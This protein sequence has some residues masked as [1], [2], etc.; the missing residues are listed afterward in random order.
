[1]APMHAVDVN[2]LMYARFDAQA[3]HES[4]Y[5]LLTDLRVDPAGLALFPAVINGF[6]RL[7]TDFRVITEPLSAQIAM[8]YIDELLASP[9]VRVVNPGAG[10]WEIF[11]RL[12]A[13]YPP[14]AADVSDLSLAATAMERHLTWHSYDRGF[15]RIEGLA[16]VD[17]HPR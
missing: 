1:M 6:L 16:W 7:A 2:V 11:R 4:A 8:D 3:S 14:R 13:T 10:Y 12:V 9:T 15:A 5:Q 17:P